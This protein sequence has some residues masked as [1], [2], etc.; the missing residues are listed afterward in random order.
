MRVR[1][2]NG[3]TKRSSSNL[4]N[5]QRNVELD[6]DKSAFTD[7]SYFELYSAY[8]DEDGME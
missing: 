7:Y 8:E 6:P 3:S 1:P 4:G 5:A 2:S